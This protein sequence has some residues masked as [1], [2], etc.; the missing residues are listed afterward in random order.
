M[1]R[2]MPG[3]L[4]TRSSWCCRM[5]CSYSSSRTLSLIRIV[6]LLIIYAGLRDPSSYCCRT[7]DLV[8][9]L[10]PVM[11]VLRLRVSALPL[12]FPGVYIILNLC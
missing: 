11:S 9:F 10:V 1:V 3:Y 7:V 4:C 6:R 12:S 5:I 8:I 2:V